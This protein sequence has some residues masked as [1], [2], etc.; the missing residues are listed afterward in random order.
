MFLMKNSVKSIFSRAISM[1]RSSYQGLIRARQ[2]TNQS[3][4][5][6]ANQPEDEKYREFLDL[7]KIDKKS[8]SNLSRDEQIAKI[9]EALKASEKKDPDLE[10]DSSFDRPGANSLYI[11]LVGSLGLLVGYLVMQVNTMRHQ[12]KTSQTNPQSIKTNV[13]GQ[14]LIGGDWQLTDTKGKPFG[15]ENLKGT[16]YLIYFGFCNC[17]DICPNSLIKLVK[18]LQKVR[19]SPEGKYLKIKTV[20]VSVDPDRD[21]NEKIEAF[22]NIF[23][24]DIIG[25]TGKHNNDKDLKEMMKKFRIYSTKME[26]EDIEDD[27]GK[28]SKGKMKNNYTIDHTVLTYLM[29]DQNNY[30]AHLGSNLSETDLAKVITENILA[31]ERNKIRRL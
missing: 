19:A 12:K 21:T 22:L 9:D 10:D 27:R 2:L 3:I 15:S 1:N 17:P 31:N 26:Y 4:N 24:K 20:F 25:V 28:D 8:F 6:F 29:D 14:A 23:D 18:G 7:T 13:Q 11:F 30:L 5:T 16:Y